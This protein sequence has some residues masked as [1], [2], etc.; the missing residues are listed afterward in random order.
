MTLGKIHFGF[1]VI[2][3]LGLFS[4]YDLF[5]RRDRMAS[6]SAPLP[7]GMENKVALWGLKYGVNT[8]KIRVWDTILV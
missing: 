3:S 5:Y 2:I 7:E 1:G 6:L 8:L 4:L